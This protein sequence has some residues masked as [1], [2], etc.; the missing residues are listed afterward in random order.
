MDSE[1]SK[2]I[3]ETMLTLIT[4]AFAFVAGLAWNEAIQKLI[5]EFY[6]A[7]GAVTG[8]LIYAVIVTIVAVVV[9]VLLARIAGKMGIDLD[10]D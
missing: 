10:K 2:M 6:T 8:L 7:G 1:I 5:E 4:T 9:T 3:M